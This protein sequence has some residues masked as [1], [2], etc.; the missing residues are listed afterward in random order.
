MPRRR[1][2]G[3]V[4]VFLDSEFFGDVIHELSVKANINNNNNNNNKIIAPWI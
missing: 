2:G 4:D 3:G 1:E